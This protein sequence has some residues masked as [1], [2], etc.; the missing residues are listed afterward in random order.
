MISRTIHILVAQCALLF[1]LFCPFEICA[2]S[3]VRQTPT[4][5]FGKRENNIYAAELY[6]KEIN[7]IATL[8]DLPG[9]KNTKSYWELSADPNEHFPRLKAFQVQPS[10]ARTVSSCFSPSSELLGYCQS[11]APRTGPN[12][13]VFPRSNNVAGPSQTHREYAA[14]LRSFLHTND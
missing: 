2:Q 1:C 5:T 6:A 9:A 4:G 12:D 3:F 8:V 13:S 10:A 11:S 7:F 14:S